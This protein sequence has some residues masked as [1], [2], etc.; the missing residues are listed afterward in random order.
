MQATD[1]GIH[2][3]TRYDLGGGRRW[4]ASSTAASKRALGWSTRAHSCRHAYAQERMRKLLRDLLPRD[5]LETV[6]Q[7]LGHFRRDVAGTYLR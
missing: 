6:S 3:D 5:T 2:N 4:S 1:R 7:E